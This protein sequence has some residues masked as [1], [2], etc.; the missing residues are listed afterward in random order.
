MLLKELQIGTKTNIIASAEITDGFSGDS[1][2]LIPLLNKAKIEFTIKEVLADKA[3]LSSKHFDA[4][5]K[6]GA[7]LYVPFKSNSTSRR[8][9]AIWNK[10]YWHFKKNKQEYLEHYHK[11]SNVETTFHMIK[12]KFGANLLTKNY[13]ANTNEILLK[14]LCHNICVLIQEYYERNIGIDFSLESRKQKILF[15]QGVS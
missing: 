14:F 2:Q 10:M 1:P 15:A 7:T 5:N 3:Y 8:G 11:R 4:V 12:Q 13:V 6:A 9:G